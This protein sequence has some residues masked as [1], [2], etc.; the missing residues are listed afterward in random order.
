MSKQKENEAAKDQEKTITEAPKKPEDQKPRI[1]VTGAE[2]WDFEETPIFT[3]MFVGPF[4]AEND[5][6]EK[7]GTLQYKKGDTLGYNIEDDLGDTHI[8]SNSHNI[9]KWLHSEDPKSDG[10]LIKDTGKR[11]YFEFL[12]KGETRDKK[13][14]NRFKLGLFD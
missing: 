8:I 13:P 1:I 7:D 9:E 11:L 10:K 4:I 3:G 12:G 5:G 2:Y 14:F 6:P